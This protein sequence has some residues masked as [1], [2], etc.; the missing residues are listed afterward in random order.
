MK[1]IL[2][3]IAVILAAA[4]LTFTAC[5]P[6]DGGPTGNGNGNGSDGPSSGGSTSSYTSLRMT[7][8]KFNTTANLVVSANF[9]D[10]TVKQT[11][12]QLCADV[13]SFL[14]EL[15]TS[16][17]TSVPTSSISL[18]NA[19]PAGEWVEV[20]EL[21]YN[22]LSEA[23][24]MYDYTDG[25]YNPAVYYS[26]DLFGFSPRFD[27]YTFTANIST[28]K[29][30]DRL[31]GNAIAAYIEPDAY[32]VDIFRD[33]ASHMSEVEVEERED[34]YYAYKP[35]Y[36]VE[37]KEGE[38][39]SLAIDLGGI[40]KGYAAD[41]V[42]GMMAECGFKYGYFDFG[43]SSYYVLGNA[44]N[45]TWDMGLVDPDDRLFGGSY[46]TIK[47]ANVGLSSSG[48]Y[49]KYYVNTSNHRYCHIINPITGYPLSS[50]IAI[51]TVAGGTAARDDALTTALLVMGE[52]KAV[53]F[54]NANLKDYQV[55][56]LVRNSSGKCERIITNVP[57]FSNSKYTVVSTI[58]SDGNIVL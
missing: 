25:N 4:T 53:E 38:E 31:D 41:V 15:E 20:D 37:G 23:I 12:T 24:Y 45:G 22:V 47:V 30:Y 57:D 35:D 33:L 40:G 39:Y 13:D 6:T 50:G 58:D 36:T 44:K 28:K 56:M 11:F 14:D 55:V 5:T 54:I 26:V 3:A 19:A 10:S 27:T 18:Y 16:L 49:E 32:Y 52:S 17:S 21:A 8:A 46:G 48:D 43:S 2:S 29:P 34:G 51:C 1:K 7:Y 42:N 9:N